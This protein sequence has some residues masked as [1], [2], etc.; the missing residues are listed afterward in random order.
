MFAISTLP[1]MAGLATKAPQEAK[2]WAQLPAE[3]RTM[4]VMAFRMLCDGVRDHMFAALGPE[5]TSAAV[6]L[7]ELAGYLYT[8]H[9]ED[10][11]KADA[12]NEPVVDVIKRL[13]KSTAK[14]RIITPA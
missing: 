12:A 6:E 5:A 1:V 4:L 8:E 13:L 3:H 9:P 2:D 10:M 14:S 11:A 7:S